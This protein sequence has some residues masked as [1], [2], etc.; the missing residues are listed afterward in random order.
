MTILR[1]NISGDVGGGP[2]GVIPAANV[3]VDTTLF[4]NILGAGDISVQA[5]L[6]TIDASVFPLLEGT[7][8]PN[9]SVVGN[10]GQSYIDTDTLFF[11]RCTSKPSGTAWVA[12]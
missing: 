2:A 7:V 6:N 10:Y 9:G 8:N 5:A 4:T 3:T 12:M 1:G 11:Y